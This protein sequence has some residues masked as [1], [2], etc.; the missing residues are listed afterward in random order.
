[1]EKKHEKASLSHC[2]LHPLSQ[3]LSYSLY[4]NSIYFYV[5][6]LLILF[7]F[8]FSISET[9][10]INLSLN[11]FD[12]LSL[13]LLHTFSQYLS[14]S[15]HLNSLTLFYILSLSI[16][17]YF[18]YKSLLFTLSLMCSHSLSCSFVLSFHTKQVASNIFKKSAMR[19]INT[20]KT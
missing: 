18:H 15:L 20:S 7:P 9:D 2:L 12:I 13:S 1:M 8:T 19:C 17:L 3:S 4:L 14:Y 16:Y 6:L 11:L 10:F 5:S